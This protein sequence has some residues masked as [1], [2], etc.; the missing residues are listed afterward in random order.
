MFAPLKLGE[1]L[2]VHMQGSWKTFKTMGKGLEGD[3]KGKWGYIHARRM[4]AESREHARH[5]VESSSWRERSK[6]L[7]GSN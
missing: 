1:L 6:L 4:G 2:A 5:A 3:N 7:S